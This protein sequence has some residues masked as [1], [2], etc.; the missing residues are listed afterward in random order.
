MTDPVPAGVTRQGKVAAQRLE[1]ST[2]DAWIRRVC[3]AVTAARLNAYYPDVQRMR[4]HMEAM[5]S[6]VHRGLYAGVD[7]D[8][9]SCLPTYREWVRVRTDGEVALKELPRLPSE[10]ELAEKAKHNPE[11]IH[12]RL[13]LKRAYYQDLVK[14][15]LA[16]LGEAEARLRKVDP[17]SRTAWFLVV[18]DKLE[19]NGL[20]SRYSVALSQQSS[21]WRRPLVQLDSEQAEATSELRAVVFRMATFGAEATFAQLASLGD[22]SVE[23]VVR[24]TIGPFAAPEISLPGDIKASGGGPDGCRAALH[25]VVADRPDV[26]AGAF[27][28]DMAACDLSADRDNDPFEDPLAAALSPAARTEWERGRE[29]LGYHV[30]RDRKFAVSR[31]LEDAV[32]ALC[33]ARGTRNVINGF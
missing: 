18:M 26:I 7:V 27:T 12:G 32:G 29:G 15:P 25:G 30:F 22:L 16:P 24:G 28:L 20:Y 21:L 23:S 2:A 4:S 1:G 6:D 17:S 11:A 3:A 8:P 14:R 5:T 33:A 13:M 9:R 31:G 19:A 10:W